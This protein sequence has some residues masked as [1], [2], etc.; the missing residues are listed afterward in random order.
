MAGIDKLHIKY[1][2]INVLFLITFLSIISVINQLFI[3]SLNSFLFLFSWK[4]I[5]QQQYE[6]DTNQL[7]P[8]RYSVYL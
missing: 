7:T 1:T 3:S 2:K 8:K 4:K 6:I 5:S